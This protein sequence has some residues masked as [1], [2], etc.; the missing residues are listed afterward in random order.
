MKRNRFRWKS[1]KVAHWD[2][3]PVDEREPLRDQT[4]NLKEDLA[5]IEYPSGVLVDIGWLPEFAQDG[6]FHILVVRPGE[7]DKPL[8]RVTAKTFEALKAAIAEA[9]DF[10]AHV[11]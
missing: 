1:G 3:D 4:A 8:F 2:L 7:F 9:V 6:S 10:A 5:Q 11:V